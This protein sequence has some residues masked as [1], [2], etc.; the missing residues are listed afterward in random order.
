MERRLERVEQVPVTPRPAAG[1]I[2]H[3]V[4]EAVIGAVEARLHEHAGPVDRRLADLEARLAVLQQQDRQEAD[5]LRHEAAALRAG[6]DQELR[7]LRDG[8]ARIGGQNGLQSDLQGLRAQSE[9]QFAEVRRDYRQETAKLRGEMEQSIE[10]RTAAAAAA[11]RA[12]SEQQFAEVRREYRQQ[13]AE[14][15]GEMEQSI[16]SR[17]AAAVAAMRAQSEQQL[18]E[19]RREYRQETAKLRGEME[20][21]IETRTAAAAAAMRAQSEQQLAEVR[22]EYRQETAKLRGEME[23]S[24][25]TRIV[26]AV[27]AMTAA[28][29]EEELAPLRAEI[30]QKE[31]ELAVLRQRLADSERSVVDVITAIGDVCRQ[32]AER[33]GASHQPGPATP[34]PVAPVAE[35]G[36]GG[37]ETTALPAPPAA[38]AMVADTIP[39]SRAVPLPMPSQSAPDFL[40]E[41]SHRTSWRVPLVSSVLVSTG[42]LMLLHYLAAPLQ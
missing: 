18:A 3:K 30:E 2:D 34:A 13:T 42:Y 9:Q 36:P 27:A 12:Q 29:M 35:P 22:R 5:Q 20:Q 26:A 15:R 28:Q 21:S 1:P 19:V 16:E 32:A 33:F 6:V 41:A 24:I 40:R 11:M 14:V 4:L 10:S 7:L 17:T 39:G 25:E 38:P 8:L 37:E 23:Q 31:E